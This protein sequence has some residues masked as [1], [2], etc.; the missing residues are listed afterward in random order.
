MPVCLKVDANNDLAFASGSLVL[1]S[2]RDA[3]LQICEH[4]AKAILG[5][6]VFAKD[7]G[8]P[9]FET[10]W[11]GTPATA[12]FEAA[13]RE[14]I[15]QVQGVEGIESLETEQLAD[16]MAYVATIRT[17]YGTGAISG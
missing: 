10:V 17:V 3:V 8:M 15:S 6:M 5:E 12:P 13:F 9:Y 11:N 1:I 2:N 4:A 16:R 14:R 7:K